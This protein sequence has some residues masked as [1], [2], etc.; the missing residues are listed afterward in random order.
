MSKQTKH[1]SSCPQKAFDKVVKS[2]EHNGRF[3]YY[4]INNEDNVKL[5]SKSNDKDSALNKFYAKIDGKEEY[6][7][8]DV[9]EVE[10]VT[11][12]KYLFEEHRLIA[13]PVSIKIHQKYID[14]KFK[15][16]HKHGLQHGAVWYTVK[17][18]AKGAFHI[19]DVK[20]LI[21]IIYDG[22]W[23]IISMGHLKAVDLLT[24]GK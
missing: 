9:Y 3:A 8:N 23:C 22:N 13:G 5:V 18:I 6:I 15:L 7:G 14:K 10:F 1:Q 21:K 24:E 19:T 4:L 2:V 12:E 16:K 20:K 11:D 17:D